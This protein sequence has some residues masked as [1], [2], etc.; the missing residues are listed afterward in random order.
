MTR[1]N[2]GKDEMQNVAATDELVAGDRGVGE[3][4]GDD[5]KN[6]SGLVVAGFEQVG[7]GELSEFARTRGNE[8]D[9]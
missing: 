5:A 8:I 2:R 7:N 4:N 1:R 9:D 3:E 6:T